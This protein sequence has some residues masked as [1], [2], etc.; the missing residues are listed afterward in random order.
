MK[1]VTGRVSHRGGDPVPLLSP[2]ERFCIVFIVAVSMVLVMTGSF[3]NKAHDLE[4]TPT[5]Y[6]TCW[7]EIGHQRVSCDQ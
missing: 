6:P 5:P 1:E 2:F 3:V 7:Q 4:R